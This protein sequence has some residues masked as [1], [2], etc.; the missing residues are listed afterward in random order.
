MRG[1][2]KPLI[3]MF[4]FMF[5]WCLVRVLIL[6]IADLFVHTVT[7]TYLVYPITWTI[8]TITLAICYRR[9]DLRKARL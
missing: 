6:T 7:T 2:G 8:S 3:P 4:V 9:L 5:C 1:A